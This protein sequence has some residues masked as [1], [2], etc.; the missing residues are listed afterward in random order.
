MDIRQIHAHEIPAWRNSVHDTFGI[1]SSTDL[2]GEE[3]V[4]ALCDLSRAFGAFD[5]GDIVGT[6]AAFDFQLSVPGGS[7]PMSG[8]TMV[9]VRPTHRRRGIL[10]ALIAAH[11]DAARL[12]GDPVSGLFASEATIYGRFGYGVAAESEALTITSAGARVAEGHS[13]DEV[14]HVSNDQAATLAPEV[15]RR[16]FAQR[17]GLFSRSHD[18]WR[19]RRLLDRPDQRA[20]T[21]PRKYAVTRRGEHVTGYVAYRQ[22]FGV[23]DGA[24]SGSFEI[25]ELIALDPRAEATLWRYVANI[26]LYP[27]VTWWNAPVDHLLPW[28]LDDRRKVSRRR[29]DTLW[30]RI[31]DVARAL[32]ARTYSADGEIRIGIE[33]QT[34]QLTVNAGVATC[35]A[36]DYPADIR[37]DR[38][39]LGSIYLGAIAPSLLVRAGRGESLGNPSGLLPEAA[40][41]MLADRMFATS[42]APWCPEVF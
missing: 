30:L 39:A 12:H 9:T 23:I 4:R 38:D 8:L 19:L 21:T 27:K 35:S 7:V 17:P 11:L 6:A 20:G 33:G 2:L 18:W 37:L 36:T 26:D 40:T 13:H 16:A 1:D 14:E 10:R 31:D 22:R 15:Y 3:R 42:I 34:F 32:A 41:L 28:L 29:A 25:D 24:P 5:R